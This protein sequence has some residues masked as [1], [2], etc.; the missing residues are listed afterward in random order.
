MKTYGIIM[1]VSKKEVPNV[2]RRAKL[3]GFSST[4]NQWDD[5]PRADVIVK[6]IPDVPS[7]EAFTSG[8]DVSQHRKLP[9]LYEE[10]IHVPP[11]Y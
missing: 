11:L 10:N 9:F 6:N 3:W 4:V 1:R 5:L 8:F 2:T 7:I